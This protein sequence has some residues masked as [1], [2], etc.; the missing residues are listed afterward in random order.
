MQTPAIDVPST[1][2]E[3]KLER[4]E[5]PLAIQRAREEYKELGTIINAHVAAGKAANACEAMDKTF[6]VG[7]TL[8]MLQSKERVAA[9]PRSPSQDRRFQQEA[10]RK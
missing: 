1:K 7:E 4:Q 2:A 8:G 6:G 10:Q 3:S 9:R 5:L